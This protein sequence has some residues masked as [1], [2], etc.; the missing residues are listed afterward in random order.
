M[1]LPNLEV[2][3]VSGVLLP[4]TQKDESV[5]VSAASVTAQSGD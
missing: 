4:E 3:P 2:T 5:S 1:S